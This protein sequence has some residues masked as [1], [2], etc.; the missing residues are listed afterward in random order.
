MSQIINNQLPSWL[1]Y[2]DTLDSTNNYAMQLVND[3]LS[4]H[5]DIVCTLHQTQGRGQ[6]GKVWSEAK[7]Q[8]LLFSIIVHPK[9]ELSRQFDLNFLI[10]TVV[11]R[12]LEIIDSNWKINIKWPN[13]IYINDKKAVGI[14]SENSIRGSEWTNA[15]IGIGMNVFQTQF[16]EHLSN[17]TSLAINSTNKF[18][19]LLILKDL[20]N[21]ILNAF[22]D[23][24]KSGADPFIEYYNQHLWKKNNWMQ[25]EDRNSN[26]VFDAQILQVNELG[27]LL[28]MRN[29]GVRLYDFG[30]LTWRIL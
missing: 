19:M 13:D 8:S 10:A 27:Q 7:G 29:E 6:R 5:G 28:L 2:F 26:E 23:L 18:D 14:L 11:S 17:A 30:S 25:F 15:I 9:H 4:Q 12:Y 20:R 3:G 16:D 24:K 21:G 1:H 22:I